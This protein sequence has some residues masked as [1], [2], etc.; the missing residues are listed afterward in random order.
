MSEFEDE[1]GEDLLTKMMRLRQMIAEIPSQAKLVSRQ[2]GLQ[3]DQISR[4]VSRVMPSQKRT[5]RR[6]APPA[7]PA[8]PAATVPVIQAATVPQRPVRRDAF[9][10]FAGRR[11]KVPDM[12]AVFTGRRSKR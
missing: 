5:I 3:S 7:V 12:F 6:V 4:E 10:T 1:D 2:A 8:T 11:R 9:S